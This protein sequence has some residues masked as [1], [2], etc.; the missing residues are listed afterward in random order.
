[1]C[2]TIWIISPWQIYHALA[3]LISLGLQYS[4]DFIFNSSWKSLSRHACYASNCGTQC[5]AS[6]AFRDS[7][8]I[9]LLVPSKPRPNRW[10]Y[11][12]LLPA[13]NVASSPWITAVL[14]TFLLLWQSDFQKEGFIWA[15][16]SRGIRVITAVAMTVSSMVAGS[17]SCEIAFVYTQ[18]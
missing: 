17:G 18:A 15:S 3:S 11:R 6:T 14:I 8:S 13:A 4:S 2:W 1:M 7:L 10:H 16:S 5:L 9:L 12:V